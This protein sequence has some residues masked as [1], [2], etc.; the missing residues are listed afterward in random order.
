MPTPTSWQLHPSAEPCSSSHHTTT[1]LIHTPVPCRKSRTQPWRPLTSCLA[2]QAVRAW[3]VTLQAACHVLTGPQTVPSS[4]LSSPSDMVSFC[5][6]WTL[7][8]TAGH[9]LWTCH[10]ASTATSG[11][12]PKHRPFLI[13]TELSNNRSAVNQHPLNTV[14]PLPSE[15]AFQFERGKAFMAGHAQ[16]LC[17]QHMQ[18]AKR[19]TQYGSAVP[20]VVQAVSF[21]TCQ[22]GWPATTV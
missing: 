20:L 1:L 4:G 14:P 2:A 17:W 19:H 13:C 5:V 22:R 3:M 6:A 21:P 11:K 16:H 15:P 10:A 8:T 7:V 12:L 18:V 9:G